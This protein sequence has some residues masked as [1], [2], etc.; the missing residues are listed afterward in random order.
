[1]SHLEALDFFLMPNLPEASDLVLVCIMPNPRDME[2]ARMLGWY[3]IP[4][5]S[6]PKVVAVDYLAF[7]QPSIFCE[8]HIWCF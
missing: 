7:Y 5:R 4:L 2:I 1:M 3:R 8:D 6:A